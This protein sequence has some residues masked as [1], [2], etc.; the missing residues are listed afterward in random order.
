MEAAPDPIGRR[1]RDARLARGITQA[2]LATQ[3][4]VSRSAVAQWETG[5]A[6]QIRENLARIAVA[7]GVSVGHLMTGDV[8]SERADTPDALALLRL[9]HTLSHEDRQ[10]LLRTAVRLSRAGTGGR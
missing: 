7:L 9:Y 4:G 3:I 5:R 2:E 8:A 1:I 10:L 6:G